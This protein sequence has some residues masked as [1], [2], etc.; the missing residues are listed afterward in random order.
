V[1]ER[2]Q[3]SRLSKEALDA[4]AKLPQLKKLYMNYMN[5]N[6]T[7]LDSLA[8]YSHKLVKLQCMGCPNISNAGVTKY[9]V[10]IF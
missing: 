8:T 2:D 10:V 7:F 3:S 9:V 6:D 5:Y 4:I 1:E